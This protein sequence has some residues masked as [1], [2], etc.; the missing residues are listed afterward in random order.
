MTGQSPSDKSGVAVLE[1]N[2]EKLSF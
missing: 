2:E 1:G